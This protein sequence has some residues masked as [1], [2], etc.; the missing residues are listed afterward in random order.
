MND[1]LL[2]MRSLAQ[3]IKQAPEMMA[4]PEMTAPAPAA[5]C[6]DSVIVVLSAVFKLY[7][8]AHVIH[9]NV[10]GILFYQFHDF[11]GHIYSD[12]HTSIDDIA[13]HIRA[14]GAMVPASLPELCDKTS[15]PATGAT[16]ARERIVE[17]RDYNEIVMNALQAAVDACG[18]DNKMAVQNYLLERLDYHQ[19]L[20]WQINASIE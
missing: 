1:S 18:R 17:F 2:K 19:K 20:Q 6:V 4:Q 11:F 13:E 16:A 10:T 9:W 8:S 12:L 5:S 15:Q 7:Y 3:K 14:L